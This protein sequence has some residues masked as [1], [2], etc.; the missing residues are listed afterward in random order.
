MVTTRKLPAWEGAFI[1]A[2]IGAP[3]PRDAPC[4]LCGI[5]IKTDRIGAQDITNPRVNGRTRRQIMTMVPATITSLPG[6]N[7]ELAKRE[8]VCSRDC[9]RTSWFWNCGGRRLTS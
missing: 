3:P 9:L 2:R 7:M 4:T 1:Q 5:G 8:Q 6:T